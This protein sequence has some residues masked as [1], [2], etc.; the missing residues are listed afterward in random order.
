MEHAPIGSYDK[1]QVSH[2]VEE[3]GIPLSVL[4]KEVRLGVRRNIVNGALLT[5]VNLQGRIVSFETLSLDLQKMFNFQIEYE[6]YK[7]PVLTPE[8]KRRLHDDIYS[9]RPFEPPGIRREVLPAGR[10]FDN[11]IDINSL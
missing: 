4:E 10:D 9:N 5:D 6:Q 2:M 8:Q 1:F 11:E 3:L 7:L